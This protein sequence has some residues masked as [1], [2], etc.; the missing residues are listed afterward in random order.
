MTCHEPYLR[1]AHFDT[2]N[3]NHLLWSKPADL[4]DKLHHWIVR[5]AGRGPENTEQLL[6]PAPTV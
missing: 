3:L 4:A 5:I 6:K 1:G 2:R